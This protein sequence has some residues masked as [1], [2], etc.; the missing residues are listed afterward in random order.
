MGKKLVDKLLDVY[1]DKTKRTL[2]IIVILG[3]ILRLIA[4]RNLGVK[5]DD[6]GK[7]FMSIGILG[8][9]KLAIWD[10]STALWF[11]IQDISFNIFGLTM[12]G[13]RFAA[14]FFGS[15]L[16]ILMYVFTKKVFKS[17]K[18]A[19]LSSFL[20]AVSPILI[21][22]SLPEM[23]VAAS[24]FLL[25]SAFF[26]FKYFESRKNKDLVLTALFIGIGIMIKLYVLFFAISFLIII[27]YVEMKREKNVKK[28]LKKVLL[29]GIII[30]ILVTPT[31]AH[32]YLL[33]QDKG[34][35]DLIFTN[36][37]G[38]GAD[39][40]EQYYGWSAGWMPYTDYKGF[41]L[42][43][44]RNY[45]PSPIPGAFLMFFSLL[46][47]DPMIFVLGFSGLAFAYKKKKEYFWFFVITFLPAFI[48]LGSNI[49]M[50]KHFLWSLVLLAPLAGEMGIRIIEKIKKIK[51]KSV[52]FLLLI[53]SLIYLG[54]PEAYG[55]TPFYGKSSFGQ[56]VDY[57]ESSISD[58]ALV[59]ADSR[60]Y[61]GTIHWALAGTNYVES[62][63]FI[64]IANQLNQQGNLQNIEVY[65]V[66]C[67]VDD[68]GWGTI[69]NQP[70]FN[71][72][73][74][75]LVEFFSNASYFKKDFEGPVLNN[76]YLPI[77]GE[78]TVRYRIYKAE[79]LLNPAIL[80]V[81]KQTH[82]HFQIPFNYDE[83]IT[84]L[85]DNYEV[86][87]PLNTM[88]SKFAWFIFYFELVFSFFA[89]IYI[90][91]L[92][93]EEQSEEPER[94]KNETVNNNSSLQ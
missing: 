42:G 41:F 79:M 90:L 23:D 44:Q 54:T 39:K 87:G 50:R 27:I 29:F 64:D 15:F 6:S 77:I 21:R 16:I 71:A 56:L 68:C 24:L 80:Q 2:V 73:M 93:V 5:A 91:Y 65:F 83:S 85:F 36:F 11:Y 47:S 81:V 89:L 53:F 7:S 51:L 45:P 30:T 78:R 58:S 63:R 20:I 35:M 22:E 12:I 9:G 14:V 25:F 49:P 34:F 17:K 48:Y 76:F 28:S 60:I 86:H 92:F 69:K 55:S 52:F 75:Q 70:D 66:E 94:E 1:F 8:S 84:P 62:A 4:A 31:L 46:K 18:I 82:V 32:N 67:V 72:S 3:F 74:E 88:I 57:R 33:Y 59:V 26:L 38:F 37:F 43:N 61:R 40:A 10:Q 19:L 13:S